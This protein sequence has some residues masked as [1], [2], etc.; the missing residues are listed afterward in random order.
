MLKSDPELTI[1]GFTMRS[2]F[3]RLILVYNNNFK[4][5]KVHVKKTKK[6]K[7]ESEYVI[8]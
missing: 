3:Q 4:H 8:Q 7:L 2:K 1:T 6:P 5:L